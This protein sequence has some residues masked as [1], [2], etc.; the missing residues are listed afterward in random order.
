MKI[1]RAARAEAK[2]LFRICH[3]E[4]GLDEGRLR[5]VI[6]A[7]SKQRPRGYLQILG[8]LAQLTKLAVDRNTHE[9]V[10]ATKLEDGGKSVFAVSVS[11]YTS[12]SPRD[13][14]RSR[15]PSSA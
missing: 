4:K 15:M 10:S 8:R 12:P 14:T 2:T 7:I 3:A 1:N 13:R 6:Q 5:K 11:L 9:L